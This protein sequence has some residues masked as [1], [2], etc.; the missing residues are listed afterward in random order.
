MTACSSWKWLMFC[1]ISAMAPMGLWM[2]LF[3]FFPG[4]GMAFWPTFAASQMNSVWVRSCDAWGSMVWMGK[5]SLICIL[6]AVGLLH[7]HTPLFYIGSSLSSFIPTVLAPMCFENPV[8]SSEATRAGVSDTSPFHST[9]GLQ[10]KWRRQAEHQLYLY[11][12]ELQS[13]HQ[14]PGMQKTIEKDGHET[15]SWDVLTWSGQC[16]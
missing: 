16:G 9:H 4:L 13:L 8:H 7:R 10:G 1:R 6:V 5:M 15:G 2:G 3:H 11:P 14:V 12:F